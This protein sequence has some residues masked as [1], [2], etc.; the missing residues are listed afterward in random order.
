MSWNDKNLGDKKKTHAEH[1]DQ[2]GTEPAIRLKVSTTIFFFA[3]IIIVM[4]FESN[5]IIG[6]TCNQQ[7]LQV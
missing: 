5:L 3:I 4:M 1:V 2:I 6:S 7:T